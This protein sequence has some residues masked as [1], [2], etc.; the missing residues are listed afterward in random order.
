MGHDHQPV[1]RWTSMPLMAPGSHGPVE[2][3]EDDDG[4]LR[5]S[6]A[7]ICIDL[8]VDCD[9]ALPQTI[10][11]LHE[12]EAP[13]HPVRRLAG[14]SDDGVGVRLEVEPPR[15]MAFVPAVHGD[16]YQVGAVLDVAD[17][18]AA[19]LPGLPPDRREA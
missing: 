10:A 15:G 2:R 11:F 9:P 16:R 13:P 19:L 7:G 6:L 4:R 8:R 12:G 18:D 14:Q 3:L 5:R 1:R 17:D